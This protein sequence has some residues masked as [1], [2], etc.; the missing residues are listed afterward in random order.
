MQLPF[1]CFQTW[2]LFIVADLLGA[3]GDAKLDPSVPFKT[4]KLSYVG[5]GQGL[6][7]R[8]LGNSSW[9]GILLLLRGKSLIIA[10]TLVIKCLCPFQEEDLNV[11]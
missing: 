8:P 3:V 5:P 2:L 1:V 10:T 6:D 7:G 11:V 9:I 4:L